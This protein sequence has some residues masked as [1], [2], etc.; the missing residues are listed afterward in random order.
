M[1][2]HGTGDFE[3]ILDNEK[4]KSENK[5][6]ILM[7]GCISVVTERTTPKVD[8]GMSEQASVVLRKNQLEEAFR[9]SGLQLGGAFSLLQNMY[10]E[11]TGKNKNSLSSLRQRFS[12]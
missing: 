7:T 2:Q 5:P 10:R 6:A 1:V 9:L 4:L 11:K 12:H 3:V 8:R